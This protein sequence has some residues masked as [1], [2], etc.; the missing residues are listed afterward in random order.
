M[1]GLPT[2]T[3]RYWESRFTLLKPG[4]NAGAHRRYTPEDIER[5]RMVA[6]LVK[7]RGMHIE[8]A[9]RQIMANPDGITRR[10]RVIESLKHI[11]GELQSMLDALHKLR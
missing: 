3:L 11:R 8:A 5:I 10:F 4:R 1:L 7:E 9:E 6:Y 2:P